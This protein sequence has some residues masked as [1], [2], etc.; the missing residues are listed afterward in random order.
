MKFNKGD[1]LRHVN[2]SVVIITK[3]SNGKYDFITSNPTEDLKQDWA[4]FKDTP[5]QRIEQS[6]EKGKS[7]LYRP[8]MSLLSDDLFEWN[9]E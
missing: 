5:E 3:A 1:I 8:Y 7:T 2:G 6:I 4:I 9:D